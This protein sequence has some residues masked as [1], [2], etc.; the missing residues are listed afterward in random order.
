MHIFSKVWNQTTFQW[1]FVHEKVSENVVYKRSSANWGIIRL[2]N[3]LFPDQ[4]QPIAFL[5]HEGLYKPCDQTDNT[6]STVQ[7]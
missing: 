7:N 2:S 1:N 3:G 5:Q 6:Q 4:H